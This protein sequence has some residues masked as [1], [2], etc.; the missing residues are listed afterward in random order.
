MT[1]KK[2]DKNCH[3]VQQNCQ[4]CQV[5]GHFLTVK[6]QFSGGSGGSGGGRGVL[7]CVPVVVVLVEGSASGIVDAV[8]DELTQQFI[9]VKR[10][11]THTGRQEEQDQSEDREFHVSVSRGYLWEAIIVNS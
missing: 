3:F 9:E 11:T 2:N 1:F 4:K 10:L 5:V 7:T 6:L 8:V